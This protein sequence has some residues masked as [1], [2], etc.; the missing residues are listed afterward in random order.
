MSRN[1]NNIKMLTAVET[2]LGSGVYNFRKHI[3]GIK[4]KRNIAYAQ[5]PNKYEFFDVHFPADANCIYNA[6]KNRKKTYPMILYFHGG[7]WASYSKVLFTTLSRR[8]AKMGFVVFCANYSLAPKFKMG[9]MVDDA[10]LALD[11]A[12]KIASNFG[13]DAKQVIF[14][15]DSAGAHLSC[16]LFSRISA[17]KSYK[18]EVKALV[19]FYGVY[20]LNTVVF[21]GFPNIK[22]L[23]DASIEGGSKNKPELDKFSPISNDLSKFPPC[24]LA[25]GEIDKLHEG[26]S[27]LF[28]DALKKNKVKVVTKFFGP[29][30][31]RAMHAFMTFDGL[32]TNVETLKALE[33]FVRNDLLIVEENSK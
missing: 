3:D 27:K 13:A 15:G 26:Q 6:E 9:K 14:A 23:V 4:T 30:E 24:F 33:D 2:I 7:G 5:T 17:K 28:A 19:L 31:K 22:T 12:K 32:Y 8:L 16:E 29:E 18:N 11:M 25:S 20:D 1:I 10:C 21:S